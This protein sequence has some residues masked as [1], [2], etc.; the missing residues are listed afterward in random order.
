MILNFFQIITKIPYKFKILIMIFFD[1]IIL[2]LSLYMSIS[3]RLGTFF[4]TDDIK[5][6]YLLLISPLICI[7]IFYFFGLYSNL[8]RYINFNF[9]LKIFFATFIYS[10]IWGFIA[11]LFKPDAFPRSVTLINFFIALTLFAN[12]RVLAKTFIEYSS[13]SKS[14]NVKNILIYGSDFNAILFYQSTKLS[15]NIKV[16]GFVDN[17]KDLKNRLIDDIKIYSD[18]NF[19]KLFKYYKID[20]IFITKDNLDINEKNK[21]YEITSNNNISIKIKSQNSMNLIN[22]E[23]LNLENFEQIDK[24][25]VFKRNEIFHSQNLLEKN[26][27]NK[28]IFISGA[29]G[30]IGSEICIQ[31]LN[32]QP[33]K[34]IIFDVNE[35]S[36]FKVLG[37]IKKLNIYK[38]KIIS[39]LGSINDYN[40]LEQ[41]FVLERPNT[42]FHTAAYKHVGLVED[43]PVQ[44]FK[45]NVFGTFNL[46]KISIKNKVENFVNISTDKAVNPISMMGSTK[47]L[48]EI[49]IQ[50]L[51]GFKLLEDIPNKTKFSIVRF[52]NVIGSSGSV[53]PI[54]KKQI[55]DGGPVTVT[56]R[57]VTRYFMSVSEAAQLVIQS[58][59][60]GNSGDIF[61]LEMGKSIKIID[62][63]KK[64]IDDFYK[65]QSY[66]S[67]KKIE[68]IFTGLGKNEK[69]HEDLFYDRNKV[70]TI[71]PKIF[72]DT[73][74]SNIDEDFYET[75]INICKNYDKINKND[76]LNFVSKYIKTFKN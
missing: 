49:I 14:D 70:N 6:L 15:N 18:K 43:N 37:K 47:R 21:I 52:G 46:A 50:H 16:I 56:H 51:S 73:S 55:R 10:L 72:I 39:Y 7:P 2:F 13:I 9:I 53:I 48:A 28:T 45:N 61:I 68:I 64:L 69:M 26:I 54:F 24:N 3:S 71:H 29:G 65:S 67:D 63:A 40:L 34:I 25:N 22:N 4:Y 76:V 75:F 44:S 32:F 36:L 74:V 30:S 23:T 20:E 35:Y 11:I 1:I 19:H 62:I 27:K 17:K 60:L 38:I 57:D 59:S 5:Y 31:C 12:I 33:K 66:I 58:S 41:I 42:I 8:I